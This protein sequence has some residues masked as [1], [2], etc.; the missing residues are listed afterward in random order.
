MVGTRSFAGKTI[1]VSSDPARAGRIALAFDRAGFITTLTFEAGQLLRALDLEN[2]VLVVLQMNPHDELERFFVRSIRERTEAPVVTISDQ[3]LDQTLHI[4]YGVD[5]QIPSYVAD[6]NVVR[7]CEAM[8]KTTARPPLEMPIQWGPLRLEL[9]QRR[10]IWAGGEVRFTPTQLRIM[11]VLMLAGGDVV[12]LRDLSRRVVGS[13]YEGDYGR[14]K[15]HILRI[16][17][18]LQEAGCNDDYVLTVRGVGF[19][20]ADYPIPDDDASQFRQSS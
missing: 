17:R 19:R 8:L 12:T 15:A 14:I 16:R 11:E 20:L 5:L 13:A 3:G 9:G 7:M 18:V 10:A 6:S 4:S 1:I 2:P